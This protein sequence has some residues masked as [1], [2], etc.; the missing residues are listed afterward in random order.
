MK[1]LSALREAH[2][3]LTAEREEARTWLTA[4]PETEREMAL[5]DHNPTTGLGKLA[6]GMKRARDCWA[7]RAERVRHECAELHAERAAL[8]TLIKSLRRGNCWCEAGIGNPMVAGRHT[9]ACE[10][11]QKAVAHRPT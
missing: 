1:E 11:A 8:R 4:E 2:A 3:T 5:C 6:A 10:D 9:E 7:A